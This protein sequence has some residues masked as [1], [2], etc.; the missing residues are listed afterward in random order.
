MLFYGERFCRL[1]VACESLPTLVFNTH[2]W[3]VLHRFFTTISMMQRRS[4]TLVIQHGYILSSQTEM[5]N[6]A[7][8]HKI[9]FPD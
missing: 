8:I 7:I 6:I 5:C 4:Y 3:E 1:L 9:V 2:R